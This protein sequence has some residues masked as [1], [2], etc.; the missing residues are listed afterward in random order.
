MYASLAH[1]IDGN[2]VAP[3]GAN[4][5]HVIN[6][7]ISKP[8]GELGHV[9]TDDLDKALAAVDKGF[10]TWRRVSSFERGKLLRKAAD[11]VCARAEEIAKVLTQEQGKILAEA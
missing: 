2:W 5:Q 1:Y 3:S 7:A 6:P 4:K 11:L 8:I 10:K 9:S